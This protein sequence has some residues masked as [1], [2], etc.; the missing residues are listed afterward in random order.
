MILCCAAQYFHLI[1]TAL[2]HRTREQ[3]PNTHV[4]H[5]DR[6]ALKRAQSEVPLKDAD[7]SVSDASVPAGSK[8][9]THFSSTSY[10]GPKL[11]HKE[12]A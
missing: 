4:F 3:H 8:G 10:L 9:D 12:Q 1:W 7:I 6:G 11:I 2:I 5:P